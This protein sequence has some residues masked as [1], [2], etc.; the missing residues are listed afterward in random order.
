MSIKVILQTITITWKWFSSAVSFVVRFFRCIISGTNVNSLHDVTD[1]RDEE[2]TYYCTEFYRGQ[3]VRGPASVFKDAKWIVGLRPAVNN[4]R[5]IKAVVEEVSLLLWHGCFFNYII[6]KIIW[7]LNY[8]YYMK[9]YMKIELLKT[10]WNYINY[11]KKFYETDMTLYEIKWKYMNYFKLII[12]NKIWI[13]NMKL[14]E[15]LKI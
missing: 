5:S 8:L 2:S 7:K 12:V 9:N 15:L 10:V 4:Q 13:N 11:N 6:W 14:H 3:Q 1:Q